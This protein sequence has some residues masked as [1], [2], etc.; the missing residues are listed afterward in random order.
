MKILFLLPFILF[1]YSQ[2]NQKD[3]FSNLIIR[4]EMS[5]DFDYLPINTF[6]D[7]NILSPITEEEV[8]TAYRFPMN[9]KK[10][11]YSVHK[12]LFQ[13][14]KNDSLSLLIYTLFL[15]DPDSLNLKIPKN[16]SPIF[17]WEKKIKAVFH[18]DTAIV[19]IN[20]RLDELQYYPYKNEGK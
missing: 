11:Q 5:S 10:D 7:V 14:I 2:A 17:K 19:K 16:E 4:F 13:Y 18:D 15:I 3:N 20:W 6:I 1:C 8:T 12:R 9:L